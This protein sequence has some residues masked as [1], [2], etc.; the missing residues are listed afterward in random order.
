MSVLAAAL[1]Y[2]RAG[3]SVI[4]V[5]RNKRPLLR[6]RPYQTRRPT[7]MLVKN[8]LRQWPEAGVAIVCG[9]VSGVA[10]LDFDPRNGDGL[11]ALAHRLPRTPTVETGG[12]GRHYYFRLAPGERLTKLPALLPG[13]DLQAEASCVI[14]PPSIHASGQPYRWVPGLALGNVPLAP[15]PLVIRQ[16]IVLHLQRD[17]ER[18][19]PHRMLKS[20]GLTIE[21]VLS[22][23]RGV[24]RSGRGWTA[25]CPSHDDREQSLSIGEG[26]GGRLLLYCHAG[27]SFTEILTA[28]RREAA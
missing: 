6:W 11:N 4:P 13:V 7:E 19:G 15:L 23:L 12:G 18:P 14:A 24:R 27:C 22:A 26:V 2:L 20:S 25:L 5:S 17:E 16:L 21:A 3:F 28:L 8:W 1:T 9:A 10:V